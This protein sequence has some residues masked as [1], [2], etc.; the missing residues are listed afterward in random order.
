MRFGRRDTFGVG[1]PRA[2]R[3]DA[4]GDVR[5]AVRGL[6]DA[7]G[8]GASLAMKVKAHTTEEQRQEGRRTNDRLRAGNEK[9]DSAAKGALAVHGPQLAELSRI[10]AQRGWLYI[11]F[12]RELAQLFIRVAREVQKALEVARQSEAPLPPTILGRKRMLRPVAVELRRQASWSEGAAGA[13]PFSLGQGPLWPS[14]WSQHIVLCG[15]IR[16]FWQSLV[17]RPSPRGEQGTSW[18]E[19]GIIFDMRTGGFPASHRP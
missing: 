10:L 7:R 5:L 19:A 2:G 18:M 12:L 9:A 17:L 13:A 1:T 6:L 11:R 15:H 8:S 3:S 14:R 4:N 16:D